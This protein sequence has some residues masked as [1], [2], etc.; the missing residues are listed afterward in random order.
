AVVLIVGAC[1]AMWRP[2]SG[3]HQKPVAQRV[4]S[5]HDAVRKQVDLPTGGTVT[6]VNSRDVGR[7]VL[8][9]RDISAP[10]SG[11]TYELWLQDA[12]GNMHPAGLVEG[13]GSRTLVLK[14]DSSGA[15]G[16]GITVEPAGGSTQPTSAPIALVG[17]GSA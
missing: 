17:F 7:A 4:L 1:L 8:V 5:A 6:M 12:R 14:G 2:W 11:R 13:G 15:K 3:G 16:A 9:T 10:P